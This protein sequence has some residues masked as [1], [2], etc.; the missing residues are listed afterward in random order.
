MRNNFDKEIL[1]I[2]K[3]FHPILKAFIKQM[4]LDPDLVTYSQV[5]DTPFAKQTTLFINS[6]I[7]FYLSQKDCEILKDKFLNTDYQNVLRLI[8]LLALATQNNNTK[9]IFG[10]RLIGRRNIYEL[11]GLSGVNDETKVAVE[12]SSNIIYTLSYY[13]G[14]FLE[15]PITCQQDLYELIYHYLVFNLISENTPI[16][17]KKIL[18]FKSTK[19][20]TSNYIEQTKKRVEHFKK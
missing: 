5:L 10:D 11:N 12:I 6:F 13:L 16:L 20:D 4:R 9:N 19:F 1:R 7:Y 14:Q 2:K 17:T 3:F 8:I 18:F 15:Y